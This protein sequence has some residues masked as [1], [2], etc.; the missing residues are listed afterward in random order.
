MQSFFFL[1]LKI[2]TLQKRSRKKNITL[3]TLQ[4]SNFSCKNNYHKHVFDASY[5]LE[6]MYNF[7][8]KYDIVCTNIFINLKVKNI[9]FIDGLMEKCRDIIIYDLRNMRMSH[10]FIIISFDGWV[11]WNSIVYLFSL[12]LHL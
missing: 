3:K 4:K 5:P 11:K 1:Y 8:T 2:F 10:I 7:R 9:Y 6:K 12:C